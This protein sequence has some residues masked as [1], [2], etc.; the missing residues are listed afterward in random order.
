MESRNRIGPVRRVGALRLITIIR[1]TP[2]QVKDLRGRPHL[3]LQNLAQV[4][5][6]PSGFQAFGFDTSFE[7]LFLFQEC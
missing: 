7:R 4:L 6:I 1:Q 3:A 5:G 2:S